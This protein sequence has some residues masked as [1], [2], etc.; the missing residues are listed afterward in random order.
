MSRQS[1]KQIREK[2]STSRSLVIN[3]LERV[4]KDLFRKYYELITELVST[5]PGVYA[6]YDDDELY[7]VGKSTDLKKR[8]KQHLRDRHLKSWTH[9]SFYL[10]RF[11]YQFSA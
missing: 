3:R 6:L 2:D 11:A 5:S 9:F 1:A 10:E 7:Y 8:V 4:S